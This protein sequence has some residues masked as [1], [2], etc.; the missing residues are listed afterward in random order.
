M[1]CD[2]Y[3]PHQ[4]NQGLSAVTVIANITI[5]K[6]EYSSVRYYETFLWLTG[7]EWMMMMIFNDCV[8]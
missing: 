6:I 1:L 2:Y 4:H 7:Y 3:A 5:Y 8:E